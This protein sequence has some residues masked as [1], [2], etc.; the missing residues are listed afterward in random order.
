MRLIGKL[1]ISFG[2][3]ALGLAGIS[4]ISAGSKAKYEA[5]VKIAEINAKYK[6]KEKNK[7]NK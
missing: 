2:V 1:S 6:D 3:L 4:A 7:D 5:K